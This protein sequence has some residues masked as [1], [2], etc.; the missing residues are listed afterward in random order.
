VRRCAALGEPAAARPA[1]WDG[2]RTLERHFDWFH[3]PAA[4]FLPHF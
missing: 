3:R 1:G 4:I 2:R